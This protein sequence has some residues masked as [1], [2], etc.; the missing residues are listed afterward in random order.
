[1]ERHRR[2]FLLF[3]LPIVLMIAAAVFITVRQ[4]LFSGSL[5]VATAPNSSG[6]GSPGAL[7]SGVLGGLTRGKTACFWVD[8]GNVRSYIQWPH[9]WSADPGPLRL[10]DDWGRAVVRVGE[11]V[12]LGGGTMTSPITLEGCPSG[13]QNYSAGVVAKS[14]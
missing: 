11:K 5:R 13:G 7:L 4:N 2:R 12:D 3:A 1:M 9:G 10:I 14:P 8:A 6:V